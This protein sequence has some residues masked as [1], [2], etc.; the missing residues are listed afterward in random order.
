[1]LLDNAQAHHLSVLVL[2]RRRAL[3][4]ILLHTVESL[5]STRVASRTSQTLGSLDTHTSRTLDSRQTALNALT[6]VLLFLGMLLSIVVILEF[7]LGAGVDG[8]TGLSDLDALLLL[9]VTAGVEDALASGG[10]AGRGKVAFGLAGWA[11]GAGF[12]G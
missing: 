5:N 8:P 11:E 4:R 9:G 1:M 6:H 3:N 12:E 2:K 7:V 10:A